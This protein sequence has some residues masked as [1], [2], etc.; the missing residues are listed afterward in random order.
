MFVHSYLHSNHRQLGEPIY[1]SFF[2]SL[3][4]EGKKK[5]YKT[6]KNHFGGKK[7]EIRMRFR[8]LSSIYTLSSSSFSSNAIQYI[9]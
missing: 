1:A 6:I 7:K 9:K 2:R 8:F 4:D 3:R 5:K